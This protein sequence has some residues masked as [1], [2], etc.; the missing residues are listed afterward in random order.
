MVFIANLLAFNIYINM[1]CN[2]RYTL[3]MENAGNIK[4]LIPGKRVVV[5]N[6]IE[7]KYQS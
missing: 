7:S 6:F 5:S 4:Y 3:F 1:M 2:V